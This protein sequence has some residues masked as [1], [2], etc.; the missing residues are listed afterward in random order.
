MKNLNV[1]YCED[2][3]NFYFVKETDKT[4]KINWIEHKSCD[5]SLL[6]Q[7]VKNKELIVKKDNQGKH[8]LKDWQRGDR[9]LLIYPNR[10]GAP[11]YLEP[12]KIEH[13]NK[14]I[15]CCEKWGVSPQ[16]YKN[17]K[18]YTWQEISN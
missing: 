14:E 7:R 4:F 1:Y 10:S 5:G 3:G 18:I 2:E 15:D 13:I 16:Y 12:I 17:L 11:F 9:E 8:C 6:D